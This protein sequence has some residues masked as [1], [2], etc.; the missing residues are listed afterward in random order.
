MA[1]QSD[2][3]RDPSLSSLRCPRESGSRPDSRS[4]G[5]R[6]HEPSASRTVRVVSGGKRQARILLLKI[7]PLMLYFYSGARVG[8][9]KTMLQTG[10]STSINVRKVYGCA[11]KSNFPSLR[12][13][14]H[15]GSF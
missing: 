8:V 7:R 4:V 1:R 3:A 14:G 15:R 2:G 11:L 9:E 13:V 6:T 5:K 12:G 10:R